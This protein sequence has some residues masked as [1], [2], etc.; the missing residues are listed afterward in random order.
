MNQ[1]SN[2]LLNHNH[3]YI[4]EV[5]HYDF[6]GGIEM[7][8][9]KLEVLLIAIRLFSENG[10]QATSVE[11]IARE[12]G[13]AKGSFYKLYPS[14][15]DLLIDIV[16]IIP[17]QTK[18]ILCKIYSKN[19]NSPVEKLTDFMKLNIENVFFNMIHIILTANVEGALMKNSRIH[20]VA[21]TVTNEMEQLLYEFFVDLYGEQIQ[22]YIW[23]IILLNHSLIFQYIYNI[24]K[25]DVMANI[26]DIATF[27]GTSI[28]IFVE[29]L[30]ERKPTSIIKKSYENPIFGE[31]PLIKGKKIAHLLKD[32]HESV[33]RLK[34]TKAEKLEYVNAMKLLEQEIT[35][36]ESKGFLMK[37]LLSYLKSIPSLQ[38][39]CEELERLLFPS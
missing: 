23:D 11:E 16:A 24:R 30:L 38:S 3:A 28:D 17:I 21:E 2:L 9:R 31:S 5:F 19:Y 26:D 10:Y 12:S 39:N 7:E 22:D 13:M 4:K 36:K 6:V 34:L 25:Q 32:M 14:K 35:Q 33:N 20:R 27:M 29:G 18:E 37:A 8:Q 1:N 15:E